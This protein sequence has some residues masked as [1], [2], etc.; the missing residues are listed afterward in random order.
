MGKDDLYNHNGYS[1]DDSDNLLDENWMTES[2]SAFSDILHNIL[3]QDNVDPLPDDDTANLQDEDYDTFQD[4]GEYRSFDGNREYRSFD[5]SLPDASPEEWYHYSEEDQELDD[6][7]EDDL[8]APSHSKPKRR[9]P[10]LSA[11]SHGLLVFLT[12]F[13]IAYLVAL[14]SDIPVIRQM[15]TMYIQTAM[16]TLNHKWMATAIIPGEIIDGVMRSQYEADAA[17]LGIQSN[18]GTVDIQ[19]LP[20]FESETIDPSDLP[21]PDSSVEAPQL[22]S[23]D[24]EVETVHEVDDEEETFFELFW[25]LD[26]DSVEAYMDEHPEELENGWAGVDINESGL[27]DSGTTMK[28]I[29]GDQ[30]LAINAK[31]GVMLARVYLS[32]NQ[33]R[34]VLAICKNTSRLSLCPA[35][36]LGTI[37]QTAGRICDANDGIL[38]ISGSAFVDIDGGGNGGEISG[39]AVCSGDVYGS[40]L[41]GSY[42]RLELRDDNKM[43][44][45]DSY[46]DLGSGTRDASEFMPAVI[47]DGEV[48]RSDWNSPNPRV[49]IGQSRRLETV[50]VVVEGRL[51]DS[52]GCGVE[53]IANKMLDYGCVQA[54]NLDGGTSAIMYY[55][56][57]YVTRCSNQNLPGGRT[58]PTAWVYRKA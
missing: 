38:A 7:S 20:S 35:D 56:G 40:R 19:E 13:S 14:Y 52:L 45:V 58:L 33:S 10:V 36:T 57:Q 54:M 24:S 21:T 44:I 41:G 31:E 46:S 42:K 47:I 53:D 11:V 4:S 1:Q 3:P 39:L 25:E 34:G 55:D 50:M 49:V 15:R 22:A 17:M 12:V 8:P 9:H 28:T 2:E 26:R 43:Y 23:P 16:S 32:A 29:Y 6:D 5:A 51:S 48:M 27:N 37:G 30:V 18:W